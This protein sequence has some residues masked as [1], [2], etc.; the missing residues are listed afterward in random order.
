MTFKLICPEE[1]ILFICRLY[2]RP[3]SGR[4]GDGGTPLSVA[5]NVGRAQPSEKDADAGQHDRGTGGQF[6]VRI[7]RAR[8]PRAIDPSWLS[9]GTAGENQCTKINSCRT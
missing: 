7:G 1:K 6:S 8:D 4:R 5:A 2:T 3:M 9:I